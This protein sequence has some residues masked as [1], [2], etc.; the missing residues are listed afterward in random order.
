MVQRMNG[1]NK[2]SAQLA[3]SIVSMVLY[4]GVQSGRVDVFDAYRQPSIKDYERLNRGA[5]TTI[6][7]KCLQGDTIY[8]SGE[9]PVQFLQQDEPRQVPGWRVET[10]AIQMYAARQGIVCDDR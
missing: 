4:V 7:Y 1:N 10:T 6:Q 8:N 3:E 9:N 5:I 2:T